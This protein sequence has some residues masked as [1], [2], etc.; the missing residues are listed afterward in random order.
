MCL[1]VSAASPCSAATEIKT[2]YSRGVLV[3]GILQVA[4]ASGEKD[5]RIRGRTEGANDDVDG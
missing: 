5:R 3:L 2:N 4:T 1:F